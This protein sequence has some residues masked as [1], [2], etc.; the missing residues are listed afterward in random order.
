MFLELPGELSTSRESPSTRVASFLKH[1]LIESLV[2]YCLFQP[3][4]DF[5]PFVDSLLPI[6]FRDL[7]LPSPV[8][9]PSAHAVLRS[10]VPWSGI[11]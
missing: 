5:S 10:M 4:L 9:F 7:M 2:L 6:V 8:A 11:V 3:D 1:C